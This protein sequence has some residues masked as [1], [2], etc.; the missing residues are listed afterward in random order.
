MSGRCPMS[1]RF[2]SD[3]TQTGV[4]GLGLGS[5]R[6]SGLLATAGTRSTGMTP[7]CQMYV[8]LTCVGYQMDIGS[9]SD[10]CKP[11]SIDMLGSDHASLFL[12]LIVSHNDT[13]Y[14]MS[15]LQ[16]THHTMSHTVRVKPCPSYNIL[17]PT[18]SVLSLAL[19]TQYYVPHCPC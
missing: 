6:P 11:P 19:H 13:T 9:V 2:E 12:M 18:L 10:G 15:V 17:C 4:R 8:G 7:G 3:W 5:R 1:V 14:T 16:C